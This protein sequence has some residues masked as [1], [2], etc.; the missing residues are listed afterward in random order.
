MAK[1]PHE[2]DW[3]PK[4]PQNTG[5]PV[6]QENEPRHNTFLPLIGDPDPLNK[7]GR[8][9][10]IKTTGSITGRRYPPFSNLVPLPL[11][12][13]IRLRGGGEGQTDGLEL[14]C[15]GDDAG[16]PLGGTPEEDFCIGYI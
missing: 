7:E 3:T 4:T 10:L 1:T 2:Q 5:S 8:Y 15:L 6:E 11:P 12:G 14:G 13:G 9:D 16:A